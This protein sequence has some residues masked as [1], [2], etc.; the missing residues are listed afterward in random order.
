MSTPSPSDVTVVVPIRDNVD[1]IAR[2]VPALRGLNVIV[3]GRRFRHAP[4]ASGSVR[5]HR[6]VTLLRHD[7]SR[8]GR[9]RNTGL[10]AVR[11]QFRR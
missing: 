4:R 2:P 9:R 7:A 5:V 3:V 10:H 1:G 6:Q 11:K 8:A